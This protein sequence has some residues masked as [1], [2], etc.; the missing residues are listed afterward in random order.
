MMMAA[1]DRY[2]RC[3]DN[4]RPSEFMGVGGEPDEAKP[5]ARLHQVNLDSW[6]WQIAQG[7]GGRGQPQCGN[8][9]FFTV[10]QSY[11]SYQASHKCGRQAR[12]VFFLSFSINHC[13]GR[14]SQ[15]PGQMSLCHLVP[16]AHDICP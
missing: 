2:D 5:A 6:S 16:W 14:L 12:E 7:Q 10:P 13:L 3:A 11:Q 1:G 4:M 8:Y 9:V 15:V